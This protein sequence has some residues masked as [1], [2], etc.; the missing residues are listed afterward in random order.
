M[1]VFFSQFSIIFVLPRN[2][3]IKKL[4]KNNFH[5]E[6][7]YFFFNTKS[8]NVRFNY[9]YF[10]YLLMLAKINQYLKHRL[11]QVKKNCNKL[12]E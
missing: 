2:Y 9:Y 6:H 5:K 8:V 4:D 11:T 12:F 10:R 7:L 3:F 1:N